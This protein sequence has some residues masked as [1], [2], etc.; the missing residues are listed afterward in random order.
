MEI[1]TIFADGY[2]ATDC[3]LP[4]AQ[5]MTANNIPIP[6][7]DY[8]GSAAGSPGTGW[9][10][11][12]SFSIYGVFITVTGGYAGAVFPGDVITMGSYDVTIL[13]DGC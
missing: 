5:S 2:A 10:S 12:Q 8:S 9:T 4:T 3:S 6:A 1:S 13:F 7:G 11:L